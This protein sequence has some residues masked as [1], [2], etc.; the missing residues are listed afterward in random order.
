MHI[1]IQVEGWGHCPWKKIKT[2]NAKNQIFYRPSTMTG[3][4][5]A[6]HYYYYYIIKHWAFQRMIFFLPPPASLGWPQILGGIAMHKWAT[7][8][9]LSRHS[10]VLAHSWLRQAGRHVP[11]AAWTSHPAGPCSCSLC[12]W[13][14]W[15]IQ[16]KSS[17]TN[18]MHCFQDRHRW[19][20][21]WK[22]TSV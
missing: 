9:T 14:T 2:V 1:Q 13:A 12:L 10:P 20:L 21:Q 7:F 11:C 4:N 18:D 19:T 5:V 3:F 15:H 8:Q 6:I 17:L 22:F 16:A